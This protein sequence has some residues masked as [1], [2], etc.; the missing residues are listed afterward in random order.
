MILITGDTHGLIDYFKL[1]RFAKNNPNLTKA[2]FCIVAGDF[3]AIWDKDSLE[4]KLDLYSKLPWTTLFVDGNHENFDL[5]NAYPMEIWK[6]GKVHKIRNDII[7]LMRGQVFEIEG[8]TI[9][10]FG[11]ATSIDRASRI[12]G[13]SWWRQE[14]PTYDDLDEADR[15][16]KKY[17]RKVDYIITHSCDER[18]LYQLPLFDR[19]QKMRTQ[20]DNVFLSN[21]ENSVDY[22][23][24]Y[25]GHYHMDYKVN[26]KKTAL[27]QEI[28][29]L[30]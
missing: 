21:F 22:K 9:F 29:P 25:F 11:G 4:K 30:E 27:Y 12:E 8:K 28:I 19:P 26:E 1:A 5:L 20:L 16:L 14:L 24:W 3:G 13:L 10:T 18:A 2:D 17:D 6:G 23:H 15:N 7:H